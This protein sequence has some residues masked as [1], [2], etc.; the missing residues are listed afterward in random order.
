M[1]DEKQLNQL[2]HEEELLCEQILKQAE[3]LKEEL[4]KL[5]MAYEAHRQMV[6]AYTAFQNIRDIENKQ[7]EQ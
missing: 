1:T 4:M 7:K 6:S 2:I 3:R 5:E